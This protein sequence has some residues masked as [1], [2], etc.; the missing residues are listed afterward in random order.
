MALEEFRIA[1]R[2]VFGYLR[3]GGTFRLV[4]PDLE[5]LIVSY[6]KDSSPQA[7]SRFMR[8]SRLGKAAA[9]RGLRDMPAAVFGR[10]RHLWMWDYKGIEAE[11]AEAGFT[12]VRRAQMG[13]S[14]DPRF[15]EV[16][17]EVRWAES[18]G[19]DCKRPVAVTTSS[20]NLQSAVCHVS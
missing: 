11:L 5:H 1:L 2:N 17:S 20:E 13:D 14:P 8:E 12:D 4:V 9:A 3:P 16:E 6:M 18:L 10:S 19:V 15:R 7:S